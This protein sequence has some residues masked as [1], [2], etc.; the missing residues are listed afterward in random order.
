MKRH[1]LLRLFCFVLVVAGAS[2]VSSP[3]GASGFCTGVENETTGTYATFCTP[4]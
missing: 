2:A 3:A 1:L 4:I